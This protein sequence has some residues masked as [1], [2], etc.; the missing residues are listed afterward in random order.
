MSNQIIVNGVMETK[1][2]VFEF[3]QVNIHSNDFSGKIL[4][5]HN[6]VAVGSLEF[7]PVPEKSC[8]GVVI[9]TR[10]LTDDNKESEILK[11]IR[12]KQSAKNHLR[13]ALFHE[14]ESCLKKGIL[15]AEDIAAQLTIARDELIDA[16][17]ESTEFE[18]IPF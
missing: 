8:K 16:Y 2:S 7:L 17:A 14:V 9:S 6:G 11:F 15:K 10:K 1:N 18:D 5:F 3:F 12:Q 4:A 13:N